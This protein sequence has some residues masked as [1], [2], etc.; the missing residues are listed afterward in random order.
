MREADVDACTLVSA[1]SDGGGE[2]PD[3]LGTDSGSE[4]N[5]EFNEDEAVSFLLKTV[6]A[7][8]KGSWWRRSSGRGWR[9]GSPHRARRSASPYQGTPQRLLL[10]GSSPPAPSPKNSPTVFWS[11][12]HRSWLYGG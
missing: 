1:S 10:S 3:V 9:S 12:H 4:C 8:G 5:D 7:T 6:R 11:M 2:R